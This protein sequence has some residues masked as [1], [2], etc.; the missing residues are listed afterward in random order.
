MAFATRPLWNLIVRQEVISFRVS[1][2]PKD[3][4]MNGSNLVHQRQLAILRPTSVL[5]LASQRLV[6]V[7][8]KSIV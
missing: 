5:G 6:C 7:T 1:T 2:K 3:C 8:T 4:Q